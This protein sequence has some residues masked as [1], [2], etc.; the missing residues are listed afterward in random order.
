MAGITKLGQQANQASSQLADQAAGFQ[1]QARDKLAGALAQDAQWQASDLANAN[2]ERAALKQ[3]SATNL[4][5]ALSTLGTVGAYASSGGF[6]KDPI[7]GR[8]PKL[9][10]QST[11]NN[12]GAGGLYDLNQ[13]MQIGLGGLG[14]ISGKRAGYWF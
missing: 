5:G 3:A 8:T 4:F 9:P 11:L 6:D 7:T 1:M 2:R 14:N 12:Y 10:G 13:T